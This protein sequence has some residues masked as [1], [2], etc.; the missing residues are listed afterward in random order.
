MLAMSSCTSRGAFWSTNFLFCSWENKQTN[1]FHRLRYIWTAYVKNYGLS[2]ASQTL[3][4]MKR[5][6]CILW[7]DPAEQ[8]TNQAPA[9][10]QI[11]PQIH[12]LISN[13]SHF[14]NGRG[15]HT[16]HLHCHCHI[17]RKLILIPH[18]KWGN[19]RYQVLGYLNKFNLRMKVVRL[20]SQS[21][22]ISGQE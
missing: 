18:P 12:I 7:S 8:C 11:H 3:D 10:A 17:H 19:K 4:R 5:F 1:L 2:Q 6:I 14:H 16:V 13:F 20:L 9:P 21:I 22:K 15:M